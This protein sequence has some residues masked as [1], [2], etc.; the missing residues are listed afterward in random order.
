MQLTRKILYKETDITVVHRI[1]VDECIA[2]EIE[3]LNNVNDIFTLSSCCG[4][5]EAG[6]I[7]VA[8]IDIERMMDLGYY[9]TALKYSDNDTEIEGDKIVICSFKPKSEC[10]CGPNKIINK[11]ENK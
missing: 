1:S 9:T 4:H 8:G 11:I 6:Y 3:K 10:R 7:I 5:G 2:K